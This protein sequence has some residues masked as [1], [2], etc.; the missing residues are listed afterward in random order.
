[1]SIAI[2]TVAI[3][4]HTLEAR[5]NYGFIYTRAEVT[6]YVSAV[7]ALLVG[8][9]EWGANLTLVAMV[10]L[11]MAPVV[12]SLLVLKARMARAA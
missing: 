2:V 9:T 11:L 10:A 4:T 6:M 5:R 12:V 3:I 7:L 8:L 1:M